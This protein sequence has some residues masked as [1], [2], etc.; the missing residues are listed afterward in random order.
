[1]SWLFSLFAFIFFFVKLA[2][3]FTVVMIQYGIPVFI[4]YKL[5]KWITKPFRYSE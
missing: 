5:F 4:I 3:Y 2:C 1:M